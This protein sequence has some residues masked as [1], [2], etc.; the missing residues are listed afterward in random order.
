MAPLAAAAV[1]TAY[2]PAATTAALT[3]FT[4]RRKLSEDPLRKSKSF[5]VDCN[6]DPKKQRYKFHTPVILLS[7]KIPLFG[8]PDLLHQLPQSPIDSTGAFGR[9]PISLGDADKV[10]H[11]VDTHL[12]P[13][14][15]MWHP[16]NWILGRSSKTIVHKWGGRGGVLEKGG[17]E[18]AGEDSEDRDDE[19]DVE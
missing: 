8:N 11:C 16:G 14:Q 12:A 19:G 2:I 18:F 3:Q 10:S 7:E 9:S 1:S 6:I 5:S 15:R 13:I 4:Q 17:L